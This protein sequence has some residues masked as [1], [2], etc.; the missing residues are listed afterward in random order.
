MHQQGELRYPEKHRGS[1]P[2]GRQQNGRNRTNLRPGTAFKKIPLK[3]K[4]RRLTVGYMLFSKA[5]MIGLW[6]SAPTNM[7]VVHSCAA[8][9]DVHKLSA[10]ASVRVWKGCGR[11]GMSPRGLFRPRPWASVKLR[12]GFR[13][14]R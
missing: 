5:C 2:Q 13:A 7:N 3:P 4:K 1:P 10:A 11:T 8:G 12:L 9:L 14:A 6:S